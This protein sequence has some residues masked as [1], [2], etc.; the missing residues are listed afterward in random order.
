MQRSLVY[1]NNP[2]NIVLTSE[3]EL[4]GGGL[5]AGVRRERVLRQLHTSKGRF[6]VLTRPRMASPGA[7]GVGLG[8]SPLQPRQAGD[9]AT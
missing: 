1:G 6:L 7:G 3:E 4:A 9:G 2:R 5:A 8:V